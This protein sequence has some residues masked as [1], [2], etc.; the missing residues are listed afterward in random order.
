[1][2]VKEI[3]LK[4]YI[5]L[6]EAIFIGNE[7]RYGTSL[8]ELNLILDFCGSTE[9]V[10]I[11]RTEGLLENLKRNPASDE[12]ILLRIKAMFYYYRTLSK[13]SQ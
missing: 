5:S 12:E 3:L 11:I 6:K 7:S 4:E 9:R 1:M 8:E 13:P 2:G 10:G